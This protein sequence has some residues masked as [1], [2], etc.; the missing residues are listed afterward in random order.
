MA[1]SRS[2]VAREAMRKFDMVLILVNNATE[3]ITRTLPT[4]VAAMKTDRNIEM[5]TSSGLM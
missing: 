3:K 4:I 5:T 1:T 2:A